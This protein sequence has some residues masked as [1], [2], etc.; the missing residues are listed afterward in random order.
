MIHFYKNILAKHY[1][2]ALWKKLYFL[3]TSIYYLVKIS[4]QNTFFHVT[5][6]AV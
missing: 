6:Q 1:F 4:I 2:D 3:N 5:L